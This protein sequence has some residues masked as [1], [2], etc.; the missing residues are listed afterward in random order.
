MK[1]KEWIFTYFEHPTNAQ[2]CHLTQLQLD[3]RVWGPNTADPHY[4][5][6]PSIQ[7]L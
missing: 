6:D 5:C 1:W 4:Q 3:Q 2:S 7:Y